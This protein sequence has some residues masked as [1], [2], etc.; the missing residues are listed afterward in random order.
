MRLNNQQK[1]FIEKYLD[2][3]KGLIQSPNIDD[4]LDSLDTFIV[5]N[6]FDDKLD[7]NEIGLKAQ[8][9]YDEIYLENS[10]L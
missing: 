9:I 3:G 8:T 6:G 5:I 1:Q 2:N 4:I 10:G 7:L